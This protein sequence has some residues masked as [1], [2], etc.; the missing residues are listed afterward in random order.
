LTWR[1]KLIDR[2]VR[3]DEGVKTFSSWT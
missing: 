1:F 3:R 2:A